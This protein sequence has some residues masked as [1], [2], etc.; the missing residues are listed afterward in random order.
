MSVAACCDAVRAA[1]GAGDVLAEGLD[2]L[3][4]AGQLG[5]EGLLQ[6]LQLTWL[7]MDPRPTALV[8]R[9]AYLGLAGVGAGASE[10]S[11]PHGGGGAESAL[12]QTKCGGHCW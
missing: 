4:L 10:G 5:G 2:L 9:S 12:A 3:D 11:G 1:A 8:G 7:A 6:G